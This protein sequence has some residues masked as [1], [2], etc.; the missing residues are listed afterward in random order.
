MYEN[1]W[2][3]SAKPFDGGGDARFY[4]PS[5]VHQGA[6]LK[7]RYAIESRRGGALL[8][9]GSG[10]GKTLLVHA[11]RRQ[12]AENHS[13]VVHL[14]FPQMSASELLKYLADELG[15]ADSASFGGVDQTVRR[16]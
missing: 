1:Y 5:E 12:L 16:L 7:L 14:V 11:L 9:G 6:L 4:Y 8:A 15:A 3:L 10:S 2:Q 13:P